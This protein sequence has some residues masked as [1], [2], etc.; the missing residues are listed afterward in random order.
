MFDDPLEARAS[1]HAHFFNWTIAFAP[2][3]LIGCTKSRQPLRAAAGAA[4]QT[5]GSVDGFPRQIGWS[6]TIRTD[7]SHFGMVSIRIG[8]ENRADWLTAWKPC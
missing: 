1:G 2:A 8:F 7:I 3:E 5:A 6:S 4:Q